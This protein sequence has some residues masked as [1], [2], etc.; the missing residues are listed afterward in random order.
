MKISDQTSISMPMRNL[1]SILAA[2]AVGVWGYF[3]LVERLTLLEMQ[4]ASLTKDL[5]HAEQK[6]TADIEKNNEFRIK[7]PRG[8]LGQSS[9]DIE[10]FMLIEDLYTTTERMQKHLDSMSN[11][12]INIEFLNKQMEKAQT[13]IEALKDADR[14]IVYKNGNGDAH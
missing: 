1:I 11:N 8:E 7:Y 9:Q 4:N 12:K 14:E 6:L 10:Q 2:V 3:G 5:E 13:N